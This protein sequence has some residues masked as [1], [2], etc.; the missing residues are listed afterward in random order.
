MATAAP[1][2]TPTEAEATISPRDLKKALRV[3]A[4]VR[5]RSKAGDPRLCAIRATAAHGTLRLTAQNDTLTALVRV[6][7]PAYTEGPLDLL[8]PW[9]V[10]ATLA[11]RSD[12]I[13]LREGSASESPHLTWATL[14]MTDWPTDAEEKTDAVRQWPAS[15]TLDASGSPRWRWTR[16]CF[17]WRTAWP[18]RPRGT[19]I[20]RRTTS[21]A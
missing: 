2:P 19:P 14:P 15:A 18:D 11:D 20:V 6:V 4:G 17:D 9:E 12:R 13:T 5:P 8:L 3:L 16:T 1:W 7:I 21:A 10:A